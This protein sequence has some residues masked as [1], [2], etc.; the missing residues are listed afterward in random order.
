MKPKIVLHLLIVFCICISCKPKQR[1]EKINDLTILHLQGSP[2]ERGLAHGKFLKKEIEII[3]SRW[4]KE[5][6]MAYQS[7]FKS[8]IAS[9]FIN[10][11]FLNEIKKQSP[12][13]LEEVRGIANGCNIDYE[14]I[15][16]YQLSE[17]IDALSN[18]I[19]GSHCTSISINSTDNNPTFLAQNMDPPLFLH[20]FPTLLHITEK[21]NGIQSYVYTIPGFIGLNGMNSKGIGITCNG[22]SMLNHANS[23]LP[24]SFIV[25]KVL[26]QKNEG[27]AFA[28][29]E[30]IPIGVPQCFTIGGKNEARCYECSTNQKTQF[31][32]FEKK[33][34]T[35]HTNFSI[36]NRDFNQQF[37]D[38]LKQYGKSVNDSYYCPRYFLAYDKIIEANYNLNY[39][40]IKNILSL[41][42]P[43]IEPISNENTYGCLV[44][45]L[46]HSPI[47]YISPGK[48]SEKEF[49]K[50]T[51][52][53]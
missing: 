24:I 19:K 50:L 3:V 5:V 7:D 4:E 8:A 12:D 17:E 46:S 18:E 52:E 31:F 16:A 15:L 37:I 26:Q 25:R 51:F 11:N 30:K 34:I 42:K 43:E 9:F 47:L 27:D 38:L 6:E 21:E 29:I 45:E 36:A 10:T 48:P 14:T 40:T 49:I 1:I 35:L 28:F 23:G 2:Y 20:G 41:A 39:Q 44:M 33:N 22:I 53:N 13:I 32:P